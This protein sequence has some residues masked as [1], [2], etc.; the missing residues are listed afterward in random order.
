MAENQKF[1]SV[2]E[3]ADF[4]IEDPDIKSLIDTEIEQSK[5]ASKLLELRLRKD[6]S[7]RRLAEL[8]G[9]DPSKISRM[10][11]GN[12]LNL[13]VGDVRDYLS[14][15]D[16][17]MTIIFEDSSLPAAERIKN[18]VYA[19]HDQLKTLAQ[20]ANEIDGDQE[21]IE[22]IKIFY[23]EVLLNFLIRYNDSHQSLYK[24]TEQKSH[25]KEC[26]ESI[27]ECPIEQ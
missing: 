19:I 11:S 1:N 2:S 9:C 6:I 14:A 25:K 23:G 17:D 5:L 18:H 24:V 3:A 15:L 26:N 7:Q 16:I 10:E 27:T 22:K 21:I 20:I 4:Y 13:K 8:M 12:G